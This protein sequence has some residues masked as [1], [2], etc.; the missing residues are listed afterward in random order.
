MPTAP[1]TPM[2]TRSNQGRSCG[3]IPMAGAFSK[4]AIAARAKLGNRWLTTDYAMGDLLV[5]SMY[6]MHASMDNQSSQIRLSTDTRYQLASEPVDERW[7][8][9]NPIAHG[10]ESK[11]GMIC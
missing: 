7:I 5:F 2:P 10:V 9:E 11:R 6:T 1:T 8:G 3:S 4:D